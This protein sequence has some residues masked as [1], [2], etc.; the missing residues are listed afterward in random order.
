M[1]A[2][3][4]RRN[5]VGPPVLFVYLCCLVWKCKMA[6][7]FIEVFNLMIYYCVF[8]MEK[9]FASSNIVHLLNYYQTLM[10]KVQVGSYFKI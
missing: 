1:Y 7:A 5:T 2:T 10:L 9:V 8:E 4:V 6:A 3:T